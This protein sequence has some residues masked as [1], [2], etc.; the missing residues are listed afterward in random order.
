MCE[1]LNLNTEIEETPQ[2]EEPI[3]PPKKLPMEQ[4]WGEEREEVECVDVTPELPPQPEPPQYTYTAPQP[5][6]TVPPQPQCYPP[7]QPI[8]SQPMPPQPPCVQQ[9]P[10][11]NELSLVSLMLGIVSMFLWHSFIGVMLGVAAIIIGAISKSKGDKSTRGTLG[12]VFGAIG[13]VV[14]IAS[15]LFYV[16]SSYISWYA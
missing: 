11:K 15:A 3:T 5:T 12:I 10:Q 9:A 13:A 6:Q 4:W 14:F 16:I 1:E 2:P 7:Q 8:N